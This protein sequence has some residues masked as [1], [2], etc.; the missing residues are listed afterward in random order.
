MKIMPFGMVGW[1]DRG[2]FFSDG[3]GIPTGRD[4]FFWGGRIA[5]C[6]V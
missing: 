6:N 1:V 4:K 5:Q 3:M 2:W